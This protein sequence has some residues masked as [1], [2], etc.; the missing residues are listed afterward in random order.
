MTLRPHSKYALVSPSSM[1]VRIT[2]F[3]RQP[4]HTS[5]LFQ[6]QATSAETNVLSISAALGLKTKVLT[7]FVKDSPI[8]LLIK[9]DLRRRGIDFE[10]KEVEQGGPWGYRHQFNIADSG[11]GLRGPRVQNDRAGEVGRTIQLEDFDLNRIFKEEGVQLLHLSGLIVALSKETSQFCL[12]LARFAKASGTLIS[13]D[14]NYRASFWKNRKEE[15]AK[16]FKEIAS[17]T[18]ILIGN[19]EDF[20]L[21]LDVHGPEA[22]GKDIKNQ[23]ESFKGLIDNVR[24]AF[25]NASTYAT[26]LREVDNANEHQWG[27]ILNQGN[28]WVVVEPR[29][30][31]VLDRIGGGDGFVGGLLYGLLRGFSL[32]KCAHFAWASGAYVTTVLEDFGLP[33]DEEQ[34]WSIYEGNARVKR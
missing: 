32:E 8:A 21:A 22:G 28:E 20:Q 19:E 30:I 24:K 4:V 27:A 29:S 10:G 18:D 31:Q 1:G 2:P 11:Y 3:D 25:P 12:E 17:L 26:T 14:L 33:A 13:F 23:I 7:K 6:M 9:Q 16:V 15:L 34:I 5:Q